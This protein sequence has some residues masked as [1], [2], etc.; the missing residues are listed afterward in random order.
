MTQQL[1]PSSLPE[2]FTLKVNHYHDNNDS[3]GDVRND[4]R[5]E[6]YRGAKLLSVTPRY[7][8]EAVIVD[9]NGIVVAFGNSTCSPED[10]PNRKRGYTIAVRRAIKNFHNTRGLVE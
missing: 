10:T 8:T 5:A 9:P 7:S 3:T 6:S 1:N 2:G 4:I